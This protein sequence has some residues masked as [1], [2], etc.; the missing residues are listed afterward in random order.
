[1]SSGIILI[2]PEKSGKTAV[3]KYLGESLRL[4]FHDLSTDAHRFRKHTPFDPAKR[5]AIYQSDGFEGV[6]KYMMPIRASVVE[7]ALADYGS[8][9]IEF[10]AFD[11]IYD[12][13][14]LIERVQKV[15]GVYDKVVF[16]LPSHDIEKSIQILGE[17]AQ[18]KYRGLNWNEYFLRHSS[19][20]RLAK[21]VVYTKD[22]SPEETSNEIITQL[23]KRST[24]IFLLGPVGVGKTTV[25][26]NLSLILNIPQ[27]SSD[28]LRK[29]Y[30]GEIG[31]SRQEEIRIEKTR[32]NEGVLD[33]WK[34][35][36]VHAIKRL[37]ED[38]HNCVVDFGAGQT[39][40]E[41]EIELEVIESLFAPY[42]NVFL[43]LPSPDPG[44]SIAVLE[45]RMRQRTAIGGVSLVRYLIT[46]PSNQ[47]I[48]TDRV[49]TEGKTTE[50]IHDE[51]LG[52]FRS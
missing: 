45:R 36:D 13:R 15:A 33:Y 12:H 34:R 1:M 32:G 49:Y 52:R 19:N 18:I 40:F 42:P 44:E 50:Q 9:V 29:R 3:G 30:Y 37:L 5:A 10:G 41:D 39:I 7:Q 43:L 21:H 24:E 51:I 4:P 38:Y 16:L 8:S 22:Q 11:S 46:H 31:Y 25:G 14:N 2:G 28:G 48:A 27:V 20:Q 17:R 6:I 47:E 26:R 23:D 35:F